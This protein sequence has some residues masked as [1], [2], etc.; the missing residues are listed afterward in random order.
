MWKQNSTTSCATPQA[1]QAEPL[2]GGEGV[3]LGRES[4]GTILSRGSSDTGLFIRSG[5]EHEF[6]VRMT[7]VSQGYSTSGRRAG[8]RE[9][10]KR[11]VF[12]A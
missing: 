9:A 4:I 12:R 3:G 11:S 5:M 10:E 1:G 7:V 8:G 6:N 2:R